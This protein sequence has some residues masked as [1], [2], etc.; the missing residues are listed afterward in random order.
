MKLSRIKKMNSIDFYSADTHSTLELPLAKDISAGFPSPADDYMDMSIDLN[1]ELIGNPT[2]TF[3]GR[4]KGN[5]MQNVGIHNGDVLVIDR[6]LDPS[7]DAIA[8]CFIDGDF[9]VKRVHVD[10]KQCFLLPENEAYDP[11][12]VGEDNDFIIWGIVTYVIKKMKP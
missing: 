11:I 1:K 8:V 10:G 6:S 12:P 7:N 3:Y 9:T 2:A 4:V 5:S